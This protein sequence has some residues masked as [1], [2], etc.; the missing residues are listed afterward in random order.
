MEFEI[1]KKKLT[2]IYS[3]KGKEEMFWSKTRWIR[4]GEKPTTTYGLHSFSYHA[5]KLWNS[6][7]TLLEFRTLMTLEIHLL[8]L[9]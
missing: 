2:E 5:A 3:I 4:D 6:L 7:Q 1:L 9:T 8:V